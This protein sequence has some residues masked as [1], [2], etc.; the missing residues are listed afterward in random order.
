MKTIF[1]TEEWKTLVRYGT[2]LPDYAVSKDGRVINVKFGKLKVQ[3]LKH[4]IKLGTTDRIVVCTQSDYQ[5]DP[6]LFQ[7][8][9]D[10]KAQSGRANVKRR[11]I[12]IATHRA[13]AE[14]WMP[15][16]EYPPS[17]IAE[18]WDVLPEPVKQWVRDTA[19]V[20]HIDGDPTNNDISNLRW[21]TPKENNSHR[22]EQQLNEKV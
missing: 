4:A 20:D 11:K 14:T 13:V 9:F 5:I 6:D 7:D 15:I 2:E 18:H 21:V 16:D 3:R 12:T 22:K 19:V 8:G 17:S 10:Y 1:G